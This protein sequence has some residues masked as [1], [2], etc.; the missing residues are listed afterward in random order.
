MNQIGE[1]PW[2]NSESKLLPGSS[3]TNSK[4]RNCQVMPRFAATN[5]EVQQKKGY[6]IRMNLKINE[7][8]A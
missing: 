1:F 5:A 6:D 4:T 3:I 8:N 7:L 2:M